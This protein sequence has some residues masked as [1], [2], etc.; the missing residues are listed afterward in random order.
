MDIDFSDLFWG[1]I[2]IG[3]LLVGFIWLIWYLVFSHIDI[4]IKWV[5]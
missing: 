4:T 3:A 2:I 5:S 1:G